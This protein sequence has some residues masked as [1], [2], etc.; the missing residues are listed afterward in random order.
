MPVFLTEY[1]YASLDPHTRTT[2]EGRERQRRF[3]QSVRHQI[4]ELGIE[5]AL[6]FVLTPYLERELLEF[7]LLMDGASSPRADA[8]SASRSWGPQRRFHARVLRSSEPSVPFFGKST[9]LARILFPSG[10]VP[11]RV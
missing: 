4:R 5:G 3:F 7:G 10:G 8:A 6:A 2:P 1:G 9:G 11:H